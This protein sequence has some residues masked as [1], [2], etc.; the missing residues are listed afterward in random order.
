MVQ[1]FDKCR[2][3]QVKVGMGVALIKFVRVHLAPGSTTVKTVTQ[4]RVIYY[5]PQVF[6]AN[7]VPAESSTRPSEQRAPGVLAGVMFSQARAYRCV[8]V[9]VKL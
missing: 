6:M 8:K 9:T 1:H 5:I 4:T 2:V 7:G 3:R